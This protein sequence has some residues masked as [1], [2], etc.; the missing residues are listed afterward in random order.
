MKFFQSATSGHKKVISTLKK[1]AF[2]RSFKVLSDYKFN[3]KDKIIKIDNIL[4]GFFG[5]IIV[6]DINV[7][8]EI[9]IENGR[10]TEWLNI[11]NSK[12]TKIGNPLNESTE[13]VSFIKAMLREEKIRNV[14]IDNIIVF[15]NKQLEIYKPNKAPI[16]KIG[17]FSD[18]LHQPKYDI[19]N[20]VDVDAIVEII[21]KNA[22]KS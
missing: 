18:F 20:E 10:N 1:Y 15:T 17:E 8:G 5:I 13:I 3:H 19:D 21:N 7:K 4:V 12:K 16:I 9:Y 22:V 2:L 14:Q 11:E 6:T